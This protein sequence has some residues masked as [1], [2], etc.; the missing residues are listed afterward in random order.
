MKNDRFQENLSRP[1]IIDAKA[2]YWA[3]ARQLRNTILKHISSRHGTNALLLLYIYVHTHTHTQKNTNTNT[4]E[5]S[6]TS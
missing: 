4:P 6:S 2:Q 5:I 1:S 3:A